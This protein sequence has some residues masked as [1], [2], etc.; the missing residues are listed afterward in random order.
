[1][2]P[3]EEEEAPQPPLP[4]S[5]PPRRAAMAAAKHRRRDEDRLL[6]AAI[7]ASLQ[8]PV[9]PRKLIGTKVRTTTIPLPV[10]PLTC[11]MAVV[12]PT[13]SSPPPGARF[14]L[15]AIVQ[16]QRPPPA[17]GNVICI[18]ASGISDMPLS[19]IAVIN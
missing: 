14:V 19:G 12:R 18:P 11:R 1:V 15:A 16:A 13:P 8:Q 17:L 4:P 6:Q 9:D 10:Q 2:A 5:T 7:D 3:Q